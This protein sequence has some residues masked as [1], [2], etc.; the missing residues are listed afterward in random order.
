MVKPKFIQANCSEGNKVDLRQA[1]VIKKYKPDMVFFEYS[2]DESNQLHIFNK[3]SARNKPF[4]EIRKITKNITLN[5]KK[6]PYALSDVYIWEN[7]ESLWRSGQNTL[8]FNVDS[9]KELRH[10][11][12]MKYGKIPYSRAVK[13]LRFWVFLYIRECY[14][15]ENIRRVLNKYNKNRNSVIAVFLQSIHW[16]HVKFL[17]NKPSK[18]TIWKFYFGRFPGITPL[19]IDKKIEEEDKIYL[20]YWR[21]ISVF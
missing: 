3:H 12:Y 21:K 4:L 16:K 17:L 5:A 13:Q 14:M 9:P 20:K 11:D 15:T 18:K 7:I 8:M 10:H 2:A 19:N 1:N 6:F